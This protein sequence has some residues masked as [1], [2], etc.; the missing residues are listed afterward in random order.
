MPRKALHLRNI[1]KVIAVAAV[2]AMAAMV[3][4]PA[5]SASASTV[6]TLPAPTHVSA[7]VTG[8]GSQ[9]DSVSV[10]WNYGNYRNVKFQVAEH[11]GSSR[12]VVGFTTGHGMTVQIPVP[13]S[14]NGGQTYTFSVEAI[15]PGSWPWPARTSHAGYTSNVN[16]APQP[17][18]TIAIVTPITPPTPV[19]VGANETVNYNVTVAGNTPVTTI[20]TFVNGV[21]QGNELNVGPN[22]A[23]V[24]TQ[25]LTLVQPAPT[26]ATAETLIV[27]LLD[28]SQVVATS[29][30]ATVTLTHS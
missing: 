1:A 12:T 26:T 10:A 16:I 9:S 30:P 19:T 28:G 23:N 22:A 25:G 7:Q 6:K 24:G 15:R 4:L 20:E 29:A 21:L 3:A 11:Q 2:P 17:S 18:G 13:A 27:E 14:A 5:L 8:E